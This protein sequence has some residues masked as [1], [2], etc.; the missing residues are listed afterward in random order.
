MRRK[1]ESGRITSI[2]KT[3][4]DPYTDAYFRK[5][6]KALADHSLVCIARDSSCIA[7][8]ISACLDVA[9][10]WKRRARYEMGVSC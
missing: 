4:T 3:V 7:L 2:A 6:N 8:P 5:Q 1:S 9:D 10:S